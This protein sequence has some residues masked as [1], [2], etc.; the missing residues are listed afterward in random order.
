MND[1]DSLATKDELYEHVSI[2]VDKGQEPLRVDKFIINRIESTSRNRIQLAAK[3]GFVFVN[4]KP[5]KSNYK[6]K[7]LDEVKIMLTFPKREV[8]LI[9]EDIPLDIVYEDD[10]FLIVNKPSGMVVHPGHGNYSGTMLNGLIKHFE[11]NNIN[12]FQPGLVHR[13]D[14]N[15]TGLLVVS[16]N[17]ESLM[18]LTKQFYERTVS[19]SYFALV[20]GDVADDIGR[21]E[22]NIGRSLKD[23]KIM[24]V[25]T[26]SQRGKH[27]VTNY[28]VVKRF[29]YVTLVE[30]K[31]ET[32]RTHQIRVHFKHINH[33]LFNDPQYGGNRIMK[34]TVFNK[35]KQFVNNCFK[36]IPRQALHAC[37]L[38]FI[39]P[40]TK[41]KVLF[42][43][44]LPKDF[45]SLLDKWDKYIEFI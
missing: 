44:P 34:G 13:I 19:R 10:S 37:S 30:C 15:T 42:Q 5:V 4:N 38:G 45:T 27:A 31:L 20:W 16:K 25:F 40:I 21:I 22:G 41:E 23:R 39:H 17:E 2:K 33:P 28:K 29:G 36:I 18:F 12:N 35:Y 3:N 9:G 11:N 6:V 1:T 32:G 14:K 24:D 43:S 8:E 7:P 26:D